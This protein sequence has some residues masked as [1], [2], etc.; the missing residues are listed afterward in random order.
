M[1]ATTS[2]SEKN[3]LTS[4]WRRWHLS[5]WVSGFVALVLLLAVT[6]WA[7]LPGYVKRV[8]AEQTQA[9]IGR[10]L[11]I[12]EIHFSPFQ[13]ALTVDGLRL[14][15]ADQKSVALS[16]KQLRINVSLSSIFHQALVL[17][18]L[19]LTAADLHLARLSA[20]GKSTYNFSDV[21]DK[22]AAM[23]KS[24]SPFRFAMANIQLKDSAITLDDS[25]LAKNFKV[26]ELQL[27]VP[28]ISNFPKAINS[29]VDPKLSGRI[30][31]ASF[32]LNARAK[33]FSQS[34]DTALALDLEQ[35][36]LAQ[37]V[38]YLPAALPI[39]IACANLSTK[40]D[41]NFKREPQ[42]Q[43][44][45]SGD[46]HLQNV[47]IKDGHASDLLKFAD[48]HAQIKQMNVMTAATELTQLSLTSPQVWVDFSKNNGFNWANL[49]TPEQKKSNQKNVVTASPENKQAASPADSVPLISIHNLQ[50]QQGAIHVSDALLAAPV[51]TLELQN[52]ELQVHEISSAKTAPAAP[53]KLSVA[54]NVDEHFNF[55]GDL[56]ALAG[57]L[58]G[59]LSLNDIDLSHY[60]NFVS[61][62]LH[63][64]LTGKLNANTHLN[65]S[66]AQ[67]LLSELS[68]E[69]NHG[70]L[71]GKSD[72]GSVSIEAL[73]I[74]QVVLDTQNRVVTLP[75]V[76]FSGMNADIR[77][78]KQ[79]VFGLQHWMSSGSQPTTHAVSQPVGQT[80]AA[81]WKIKVGQFD[82]KDSALA[83]GDASVSPAVKLNVNA[84][85]FN[86][87]QLNSDLS[88]PFNMSLKSRFGRKGQFNF[89]AQA[90]PKLKQLSVALDT[91]N[92]PLAA[93][94]P[95]FSRFL[96]VEI[97]K[98]N[99]SAKGKLAINNVLENERQVAYNGNFNLNDFKIYEN[100]SDE[101]FLEWKAI[102]LDGIST[103]IGGAQDVF[104]LKKL[105]L[106]DFFA[107]LVLS[108]KA[109]L[110]LQDIVVKEPPQSVTT[111]GPAVASTGAIAG[112]TVG[113]T[114]IIATNPVIEHVTTS[115]PVAVV[116]ATSASTASTSPRVPKDAPPM[117]IR[118]AQTELHGGN[119]NFT[120]NFI[121]P[122]YHANLTNISG[123]I[124]LIAS[125]NSQ[126]ANLELHGTVDNDAPLL[127]SG[128][129]NPLAS[130]IYLD[131]IGSTN[132]L[133]LTRLTPY[134]AK[135]AGYPIEKGKL[136][137]QV[138]YHVENQ[139][140]KADNSVTLDQLTFG[141][142]VDGPNVTKLPVMLAVALL[143]DNQGRIAIN[144][145]IS[146]S[147]SDPQFSVGGIIFKVF[148]NLIT[149]AVTSPFAL[150][151]SM[152]GGSEQLAYVEFN[153]GLAV[154]PSAATEKL[155]NLA[156]ALNNRSGLKLDI[157][158]R[159]DPESDSD[160]VRR[161]LLETKMRE[162]KWREV[163]QKDRSIK[164]ADVE[165]SAEDRNRYLQ[166]V[167]QSEK[168]DKPR[169]F[170]GMAK[171][172]PAAE[173]EALILKNLPVSADDLRVLAQKRED[174]VRDYLENT[175]KVDRD[176]L[177]LI[178][179]KLDS[180]GIKDQGKPNRVD[181]SLK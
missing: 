153:P 101:D 66:P 4:F 60:Q 45:L 111:N 48:L 154:L 2:I 98:G 124:G 181:F 91:Q 122:N 136:S 20:N 112:T 180:S 32:A 141:E 93:F 116:Q 57:T 114:A 70:R 174:V 31:G 109:K 103:K 119:I 96:N 137:M 97:T 54:T 90:T 170:I 42:A 160:G 79:A 37:Y 168:F 49:S 80:K 152:F 139:H 13:L 149:K 41:L 61:P 85:N 74:D 143:R 110:N 135:Y 63:A 22:I 144:L 30:N 83:F 36:D 108:D 99:V 163:H 133:E 118:I 175:G 126:A 165:L 148:V 117:I 33:P 58:Q 8:A 115:V 46:F 125:D 6:S 121:K 35:L 27:G 169:N 28:F 7:F 140:L 65:F 176:R 94:Y 34:L 78:D 81:P 21:L 55:E 59:K 39:Q 132:G 134:S 156:K 19:E 75:S 100:G 86:I 155:D 88:Q 128:A 129:V 138:S 51:Q 68:L 1:T 24:D 171:T 16:V 50:I 47:D 23:P 106:N 145:P 62:F 10:K 71:Q 120:D 87:S 67:L 56:Q 17:N 131:I 142:H 89:T 12:D 25:V 43:I 107:R 64:N 38:A 11:E 92:V 77:R 5:R 164:S 26:T 9:Q 151:G 76:I 150:I 113:A 147:L 105:S 177:F 127:I 15:E 178:A 146:G 179:P 69:V 95:Y 158:G 161:N 104:D 167:Y 123:N 157:I 44:L 162:A 130:P 72:D 52:F 73:K 82:L 172:L 166:I 29:F 14:F 40:L 53:V 3:I 84:I 173:A 18:E 159:V 102:A